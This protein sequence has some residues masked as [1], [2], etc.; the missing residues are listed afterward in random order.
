M[1]GSAVLIEE[2]GPLDLFRI[3]ESLLEVLVNLH[4]RSHRGRLTDR[5]LSCLTTALTASAAP[6][7]P[8]ASRVTRRKWHTPLA[9]SRTALLGRAHAL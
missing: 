4:F 3:S 6:G 2:N 8:D 5:P 9:V 7:A 1:A